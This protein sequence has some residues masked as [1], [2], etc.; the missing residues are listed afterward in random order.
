LRILLRSTATVKEPI[1]TKAAVL[2]Y[3]RQE[4]VAQMRVDAPDEKSSL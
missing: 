3:V 4:E 1:A 2:T